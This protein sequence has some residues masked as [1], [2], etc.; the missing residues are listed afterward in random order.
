MSFSS[1]SSDLDNL[2]QSA[3]LST[4]LLVGGAFIG[5]ALIA[6]VLIP[7][8]LPDLYNSLIGSQPQAY[9]FLSRGSALVAYLL[10][11]GSMVFGVLLTNKMA[12]VWPGG[13]T[14]YSLHEFTSLLGMGFGL[15]HAL[16]L[17]GDRFINYNLAQILMPF[18]STGFK[19][20]WVGLGQLGFYLLVL[21]NLSFYVRQ[22]IGVRT[23]RAIHY[24]SFLTFL[25][26]LIHG[27]L[28]GTDTGLSWVSDMYWITGGGLLFL[29]IYR[30][31]T[32][33]INRLFPEKPVV[34]G[35]RGA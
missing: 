29:T 31:L 6:V 33:V 3:S 34:G 2:P 22:Q 25:L 15:F 14:A 5:G 27:L 32:A 1:S 19:P 24:A 16:I 7:A 20:F 35:R 17:L 12:R 13:P 21:V 11:W 23:W 4:L 26:A 30:L 10:L 28:S 18:G 9:W 8:W